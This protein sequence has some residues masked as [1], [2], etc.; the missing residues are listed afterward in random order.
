MVVQWCHKGSAKHSGNE[1]SD[2][3]YKGGSAMATAQ[4]GSSLGAVPEASATKWAARLALMGIIGPV[5][6][7]VAIAAMH[8]LRPDDIVLYG[9][10]ISAYSI[11]AYGSISMAAFVALG[12]SGLALSAGLRRAVMPSRALRVG[13]VLIGVF[14]AGWI[15]AGIFRF[16]T[17]A[18]SLE[19][20][21]KGEN[22]T[23]SEA[24]HGLG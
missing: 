5:F 9:N 20:A 4:Q 15:L 6:Y 11:G 22:P 1:E 24:I 23:I 12:L 17:D 21:I 8:F 10:T 14:G 16:G 19:Q 7:V 18:A 3:K 2:R 13:S